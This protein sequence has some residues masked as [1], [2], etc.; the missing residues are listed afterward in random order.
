M[1]RISSA[2]LIILCVYLGGCCSL[3]GVET[4]NQLHSFIKTERKAKSGFGGKSKVILI[5]D[6]RGSDEVYE[7]DMAALKEEVE[8][9]I[10]GHPELSDATKNNLRELK[11]A[12]GATKQEVELLLG[13]PDKA[14][15]SKGSADFNASEVWIYKIN[16]IRAFT[17]FIIPVF[18]VHEGYYL[19]FKDDALAGIER[20]YLKQIV[21][22]SAGAGVVEKK[23]K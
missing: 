7:E 12:P 14:E 13:A 11:V 21:Q 3:P 5:K 23:S 10:S 20:H 2:I 22:Q 17:V 15:K 4:C 16:K 19:Y 6:F 18:F 9:Y 1:K 8:K